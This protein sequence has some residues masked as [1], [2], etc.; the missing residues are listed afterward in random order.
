[1]RAVDDLAAAA[2]NGKMT[3]TDDADA[4]REEVWRSR[5]EEEIDRGRER[6]IVFR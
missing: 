3:G 4:R 2:E 6:E 5:S 1:M